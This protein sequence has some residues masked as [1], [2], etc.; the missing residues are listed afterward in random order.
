MSQFTR[1]GA[2]LHLIVAEKPGPYVASIRKFLA[3]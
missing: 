3:R 1:R 2:L